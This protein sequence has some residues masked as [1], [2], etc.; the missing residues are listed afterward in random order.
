VA[1]GLKTRLGLH[2]GLYSKRLKNRLKF[3][4]FSLRVFCP[5]YYA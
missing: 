4:N 3:L 2:L 5:R 1:L